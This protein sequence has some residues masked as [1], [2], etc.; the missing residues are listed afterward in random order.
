MGICCVTQGTPKR[1]LWQ[2]EGWDGEGYGRE[3]REGGD[4]GYTYGWFLLTY[5]RKPQNSVKQ[6][7]FNSKSLKKESGK[8]ITVCWYKDG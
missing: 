6:L 4:M 1:A 7:S 5:D 2:A 3:V 8:A